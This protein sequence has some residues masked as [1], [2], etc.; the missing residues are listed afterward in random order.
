MDIKTEKHFLNQYGT[1]IDY[2][3]LR[4]DKVKVQTKMGY[5]LRPMYFIKESELEQFRNCIIDAHGKIV[6]TNPKSM[7]YTTSEL[8]F[9]KKYK[10]YLEVELCVEGTHFIPDN[11]LKNDILFFYKINN[12]NNFFII[13]KDEYIDQML[14]SEH[15]IFGM[16]DFS[17]GK[18]LLLTKDSVVKLNMK[19]FYQKMESLA[20]EHEN[21]MF[22]TIS[23]SILIKHSFKVIEENNVLQFDNLDFEKIIKI[24]KEVRRIIREIFKMGSYGVFTYGVNK[25]K[26]LKSSSENLFHTGILS[27][28]FK[29]VIEM[30]EKCRKFKKEDRGDIYVSNVLYKAFMFRWRKKFKLS[31]TSIPFQSS[32][33]KSTSDENIIAMKIPDIPILPKK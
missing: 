4:E 28:E 24:F 8:N 25:C 17:K 23:D 32:E 20:K 1:V 21:I 6:I 26:P 2:S 29:R 7:E 15:S 19:K 11:I 5:R 22:V 12:V 9:I 13:I 3:D 33:E 18:D 16:I 27:T 14:N 30:E 10:D 31:K